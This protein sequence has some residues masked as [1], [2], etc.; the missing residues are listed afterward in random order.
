MARAGHL[1]AVLA[2][3]PTDECISWPGKLN[4]DGYGQHRLVYKRLVGPPPTRGS[5][6]DLDHLCRNR[7]CVNPAHLEVVTHREN[8]LRGD[9]VVAK[10]ARKTHCDHGH[11]FTPENTRIMPEGWRRCRTCARRHMEEYWERIGK[12][13]TKRS[14]A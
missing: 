10:N 8:T 2:Q 3:L 11:E 9:T 12:P 13:Y 6:Y 7:A 1:D 5:G 14:A 4:D